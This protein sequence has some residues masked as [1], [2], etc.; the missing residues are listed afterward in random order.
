[1]PRDDNH[2]PRKHNILKRNIK[3]IVKENLIADLINI[4]WNEVLS[5]T[6]M[7]TNYSFE[8]FDEKINEIIDKHAP[9][10]A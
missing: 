2:P 7:D 9:L 3:S 10:R 5:T 6:K 8:V 4:D 1:M